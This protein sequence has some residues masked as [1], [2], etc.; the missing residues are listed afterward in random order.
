[1]NANLDQKR[2]V[3][4]ELVLDATTFE[5]V[6]SARQRLRDWIAAHP[7]EREWMRDGFEQLAQ[8]EECARGQQSEQPTT[9]GAH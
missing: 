9:A 8:M 3:L 4:T 6:Q 7:E 5:E 1:M 2:Q